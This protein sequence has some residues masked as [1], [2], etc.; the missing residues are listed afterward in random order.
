MVQ[1]LPCDGKLRVFGRQ[2]PELGGFDGAIY[3]SWEARTHVKRE[4]TDERREEGDTHVRLRTMAITAESSRGKMRGWRG[5][6]YDT[7]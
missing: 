1:H 7:T 6:E 3:R 4:S 2:L 5:Y